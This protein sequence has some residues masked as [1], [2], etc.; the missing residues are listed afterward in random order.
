V[1]RKKV[2]ISFN[3][4]SSVITF[5]SAGIVVGFSSGSDVAT[6][7]ALDGCLFYNNGRGGVLSF[8]EPK[9]NLPSW[10]A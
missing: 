9:L 3:C 6:K 8:H 10:G 2:A 7:E 5:S 1:K 4:Y